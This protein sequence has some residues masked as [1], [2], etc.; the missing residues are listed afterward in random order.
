MTQAV[1]MCWRCKREKEAAWNYCAWCSARLQETRTPLPPNRQIDMEFLRDLYS[2]GWYAHHAAHISLY[3]SL[4]SPDALCEEGRPEPHGSI[5][6]PPRLQQVFR[7]QMFAE[8]VALMEAFGMLCLSIRNRRE[9]S[10]LWSYLNSEPGEVD[11][12]YEYLLQGPEAI[13]FAEALK[14]PSESTIATATNVSPAERDNFAAKSNNFRLIAEIYRDRG[15]L[16]QRAYNKV[17]HGFALSE[18]RFLSQP[19]DRPEDVAIIV[20]LPAAWSG[21]GVGFFRLPMTQPD[22]DGEIENVHRLTFLGADLI[23]LALLLDE[24]GLLY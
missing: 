14:L 8:F 7:A 22:I 3:Q 10:I 11:Q 9:K 12:F 20:E 1:K 16:V 5:L 19:L 23:A 21:Q 24:H 13:S 15:R 4:A 2:Y 17:K 6:E 18:G